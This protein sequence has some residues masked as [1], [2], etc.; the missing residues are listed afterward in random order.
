MLPAVTMAAALAVAKTYRPPSDIGRNTLFHRVD[1]GVLLKASGCNDILV[2]TETA[3][4]KV[5]VKR[6]SCS[7][8]WPDGPSGQVEDRT[9][10]A[11][12]MDPCL[13]HPGEDRLEPP[14][15]D[16]HAVEP[17]H[18]KAAWRSMSGDCVFVR[19][20][21]TANCAAH[22]VGSQNCHRDVV[23]GPVTDVPAAGPD[24]PPT[25]RYGYHRV[26]NVVVG[27]YRGTTYVACTTPDVVVLADRDRLQHNQVA[28]GAVA[29][30]YGVACVVGRRTCSPRFPLRSIRL[31]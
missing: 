16:S 21:G 7:C 20:N 11:V 9:W 30:A 1:H 15:M 14:W 8:L 28:L 25:N 4:A 2:P 23:T 10:T 18:A 31:A 5:V 22:D 17:W 12:P 6:V 27:V 13:V 3:T 29:L 24:D 19:S 26:H